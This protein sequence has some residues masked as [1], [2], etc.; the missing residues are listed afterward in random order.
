MCKYRDKIQT[1]DTHLRLVLKTR[2]MV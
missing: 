2:S 1:R